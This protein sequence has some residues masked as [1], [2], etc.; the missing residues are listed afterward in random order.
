MSHFLIYFSI[1]NF[2][3]KKRESNGNKHKVFEKSEIDAILHFV[4]PFFFYFLFS[5]RILVYWK[6][7][8]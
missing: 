1:E 7:Y 6:S 3:Q 8:Y 4:N 5:K 2:L